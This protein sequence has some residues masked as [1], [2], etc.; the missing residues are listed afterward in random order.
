M[1]LSFRDAKNWLYHVHWRKVSL[2][3]LFFLPN[4]FNVLFSFSYNLSLKFWAEYG[5]TRKVA[6]QP[7][8]QNEP[9]LRQPK[10]GTPV[11]LQIG[12]TPPAVA[13]HYHSITLPL[14]HSIALSVF[15]YL[16]ISLSLLG[17]CFACSACFYLH[18]IGRRTGSGVRVRDGK[19][20]L[21]WLDLTLVWL[22]IR[23]GLYHTCISNPKITYNQVQVRRLPYT[24]AWNESIF[25]YDPLN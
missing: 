24:R 14:D 3:F 6:E 8:D 2:K 5:H 12:K 21:T 11:R 1:W 19:G 25:Y 15:R 20:L 16:L 17:C 10:R 7:R 22:L 9:H 13:S 23:Q 18:E 4:F